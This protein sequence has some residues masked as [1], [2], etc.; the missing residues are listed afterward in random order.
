MRQPWR[1]HRA[2]PPEP[3]A[4]DGD[5]Q[6]STA[7]GASRASARARD[8]QRGA[9]EVAARVAWET[10]QLARRLPWPLAPL[11]RAAAR[12]AERVSRR[13]DPAPTGAAGATYLAS[14]LRSLA[15]QPRRAALREAAAE[16]ARDLAWVP[17]P[18]LREGAGEL[19]AA[20]AESPP[21]ENVEADRLATAAAN[22]RPGPA[23][24]RLESE[25][26]GLRAALPGSCGSAGPAGS[27]WWRSAWRP[28]SD[29]RTALLER[30]DWFD[31]YARGRV[32]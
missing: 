8:V 18:S 22:F 14:A 10:S 32:A 21:E 16:Y 3:A 19:A 24:A 13:L 26:A 27:A 6:E 20:L 5:R 17:V 9:S 15:A 30:A 12:L 25:A 28:T 29:V 7:A 31:A 4:A 11:S 2:A 23:R 1:G